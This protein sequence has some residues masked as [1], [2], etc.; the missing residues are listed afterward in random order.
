MKS[1]LVALFGVIAMACASHHPNQESP[2]TRHNQLPPSIP[3]D[4]AKDFKERNQVK[5]DVELN[6]QEILKGLPFAFNGREISFGDEDLDVKN[7]FTSGAEVVVDGVRQTP[8]SRVFTSKKDG[9]IIIVKDTNG[10]LVSATKKDQTT[11]KSTEVNLISKGGNAYATVT[12]DDLDDKK[13]EHFSLEAV[14]PPG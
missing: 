5:K 4:I 10:N 12:S 13:L 11:G 7:V 1:T 9:D 3:V 2:A 14:M 6:T 8:V